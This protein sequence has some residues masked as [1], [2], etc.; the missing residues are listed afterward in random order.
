MNRVRTLV[1]DS[2]LRELVEALIS[3]WRTVNDQI[4]KLSRRLLTIARE[5]Q[6]VKRLMTAPGVGVLVALTATSVVDDPERFASPSSVG[7]Y[8]GLTPR[9]VQPGEDDYAG[10][11]SK[12]GDALP[13]TYLFEAAGIILHRVAK[14]SPLK[15]WGTQLA[16]RV[17]RKKATVAVARKLAGILYRMWKDGTVFRWSTLESKAG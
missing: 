7:A 11:I 1:A 4:S 14:W 3:A 17:G 6:T 5:D 12:R 16:R 9:R 2:L 8:V 15:A 10:H 13:R